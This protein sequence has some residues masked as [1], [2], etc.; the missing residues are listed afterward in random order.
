MTERDDPSAGHPL[1]EP[2]FARP[3]SEEIAEELAFHLEM[4]ARELESQGFDPALARRMALARFSDVER[5]AEECRA[6]AERREDTVRRTRYIR[7]FLL[8]IRFALRMLGRRR[9]FAALATLTIGLG[10]GAATAIYSVV[11]GVLLRPLPYDE[12]HRLVAVWVTEAD[13]KTDPVLSRYWD[14][15][16]LGRTEYDALRQ[17]ST[18]LRDVSLWSP[19][20]AMLIDAAGSEEI[21]TLRISSGLLPLLRLHPALGRS[22]LP[23]EDAV[24]GPRVAMVSW[25]AWQS[26]WG[27]DASIVGRPI[28]LDENSY[29]IV[30]VLPRKLRL[31]RTGPIVPVWVPAFQDSFDLAERHNRSYRAVARLAPGATIDEA[32]DEAS[33]ILHAVSISPTANAGARVADWQMDQ[34]GTARDSLLLLLGAVGLLLCIACV[35]VSTLMLGESARR[36]PEIAARSALGAGPGRLALQLLAESLVIAALGGIL[37]T[38]IAAVSIRLLVGFAPPGIPGIGDV[39]LDWRVLAFTMGCVVLCGFGFGIMPAILLLRRTRHASIR[40]GAG[41]SSRGAAPLQRVLIGLEVALSLVLL[42]GC[43]L[44]GRSLQRLSTVDPG[45]TAENRVVAQM[46]SQRAFWRSDQRIRA[47]YEQA[48]RELAAL[49]GVRAVSGSSSMPFTGAASSSPVQIEGVAYA[50]QHDG[51][52]V[53]QRSVL[54]NFFQVIGIPLR[55]GR[56]FTAEDR[57]GAEAVVIISEVEARRD[58]PD[59]SPLGHRLRWQGGWRTVVGVVGDVK[60]SGLSR[61]AEP[62]LYVPF[63]QSPDAG[64][65]FILQFQGDARGALPLIRKRLDAIDPAAAV[66]ALGLLPDLIDDSYGDEKFRTL[67]VTLFGAVAG[68]LAAVGIF[69]VTSRTVTRRLREAGIRVAL[70]AS[71]PALTRLMLRDT[72]A[73]VGIGLLIGVPGA[74]VAARMLSPY[75]YGITSADPAAYGL[76]AGLLIGCAVGATIP[77]LRRAWSVDPVTVLKTE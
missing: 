70:G 40:V 53:Q 50:G 35:N 22:F 65:T 66:Y 1:P 59:G 17:H 15:V 49:P 3:V 34:T 75:L 67:L 18:R 47:F 52:N 7:N 44:L 36:E 38:A 56:F 16:V 20:D 76:G 31:S 30:G 64:T 8:D 28:Q 2:I 10:I 57:A 68:V 41:Q 71:M 60:Y 69:G 26:R 48:L 5:V 39:A 33:R 55:A 13:R 74:I 62:T 61:D 45:F 42:V 12:P 24:N 73:G 46:T 6:L 63:D 23:G 25:E 4:R 77:A 32:T 9:G 11:D 21:A 27:G 51:S 72:L 58:W 19:G 37:G 29:T 14:R 43:A 54:P